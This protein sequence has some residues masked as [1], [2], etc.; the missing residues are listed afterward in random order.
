MDR[1]SKL[2]DLLAKLE[3]RPAPEQSPEFQSL[4]EAMSRSLLGGYDPDNTNAHC[5]NVS[6]C[7]N[8]EWCSGNGGCN[9]NEVCNN[10]D[11]CNANNSCGG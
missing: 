9:A 2:L 7:S 10:N 4:S 1:N 5:S 3:S 6:V 11:G 8:N